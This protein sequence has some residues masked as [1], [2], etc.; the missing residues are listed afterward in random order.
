MTPATL[1]ATL[2]RYGSLAT[3]ADDYAGLRGRVHDAHAPSDL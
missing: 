2:S 1:N 3:Q